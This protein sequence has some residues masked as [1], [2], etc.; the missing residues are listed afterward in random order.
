MPESVS[1]IIPV[2]NEEGSLDL[3]F[4]RLFAV[5]D[6]MDQSF[7][8]IAVNDGSADRTLDRLRENAAR[9]RDLKVIDFVRNFGQTAAIQAGIDHA[10]GEILVCI[11]A[12]L[13]NDPEDI[14]ALIAKLNEGYG[15][16]SGWRRDRQDAPIRRNFV[17]RVANRLISAV[18]GVRLNDYGCTLKAYRREVI[19]DVHLYG[20]MHRFIPIYASWRGARI[21]ELPVRHAARAHGKSSYGL[22]RTIKILLD[23]LVVKFLD[24][25]LVKPIYVFGSFGLLSLGLSLVAG[26]YALYLKFALGVSLIQTPLPLLAAMTFLV[27]FVSLLMGLNAEILTR[28][29][30]ESQG[31]S[32]YVVRTRINV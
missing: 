11:D 16:V 17:S 26:A 6:A 14:P 12:D 31:R 29:Y 30:F 25:H 1:I 13:Q 4:Q 8:V 21:A 7:E 23:L 27:G 5:L 18:S 32:T 20:E 9:R 28:T 22:E 2:Y 15:V 3:L 19:K 10:A 24:R